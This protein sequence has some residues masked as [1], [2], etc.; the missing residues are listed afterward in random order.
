M[1][2]VV[3]AAVVVPACFGCAVVVLPF[4]ASPFVVMDSV[5]GVSAAGIDSTVVDETSSVAL[6]PAI[7]VAASVVSVV[8]STLRTASLVVILA[9]ETAVFCRVA[10]PFTVIVETSLVIAFRAIVVA[11]GVC[12]EV[13][14]S[15]VALPVVV[16]WKSV[17]DPTGEVTSIVVVTEVAS[18][19]SLIV[20]L[21]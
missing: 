3:G 17:E 16:I 10:I 19:V 12:P 14:T 6:T 5:I 7:V 18:L 15:V 8:V 9:F 1:V 13:V 20:V 2:V 11:A 4:V 21:S